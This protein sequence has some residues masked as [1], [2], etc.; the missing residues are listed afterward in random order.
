MSL[1]SF[2]LNCNVIIQTQSSKCFSFCSSQSAYR[3]DQV[4]SNFSLSFCFSSSLFALNILPY[5]CIYSTQTNDLILNLFKADF[6][7]TATMKSPLEQTPMGGFSWLWLSQGWPTVH[8][9]VYYW[10]LRCLFCLNKVNWTSHVPSGLATGTRERLAGSVSACGN[11]S[12][13]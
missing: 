13:R 4:E 10:P 1:W 12:V 8:H 9:I 3:Q 2:I 7:V 5:R 11:S 6:K